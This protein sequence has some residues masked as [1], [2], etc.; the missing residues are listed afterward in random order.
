MLDHISEELG[1]SERKVYLKD[2]CEGLMLPLKRKSI[3]S[4]A[5]AIDPGHVPARHQSPQHFV[6]D[7]PWP[8]ESVLSRV[9]SWVLPKMRTERKGWVFLIADDTGTP[10]AGAHSV[11]VARQYWGV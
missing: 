9:Q 7:S 2:Y 3:G 1:R 4:L 8:D 11:G 5:A 10:K 6:A